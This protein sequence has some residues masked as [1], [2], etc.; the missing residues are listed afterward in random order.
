MELTNRIKRL[1]KRLSPPGDNL[2]II[3]LDGRPGSED[4]R[5]YDQFK[6][7]LDTGCAVISKAEQCLYFSGNNPEETRDSEICHL[8]GCTKHGK[9]V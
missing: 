4:A 1:E 2:P 5:P 8:P 6:R 3:V 9:G 7:D